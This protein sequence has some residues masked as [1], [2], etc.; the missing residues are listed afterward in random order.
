MRI[1]VFDTE[2]TGLPKR[3]APLSEQPY[4]IQFASQTFEYDPATRRFQEVGRYSQLIKPPVPIPEES[5]RIC[6]ISDQSVINSP[7]FREVAPRIIEIFAG[8]DL[9]VAHNLSFDQEMLGYELERNG[10]SPNIYPAGLYD[11]LEGT[12]SLCKLPGK[13]GNYKAPR[14]MELHQFLLNESFEEAHDA[15]KD[16][17]ALARCLRVLLQEGLYQPETVSR[18]M[19][20]QKTGAEQASMF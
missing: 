16:V 13:N 18:G 19:E 15:A 14:L 8:S 12:R 4:V 10:F 1:T 5:T 9:V 3:E 7:A 6:R 20:Q 11:T 17:E 2:T